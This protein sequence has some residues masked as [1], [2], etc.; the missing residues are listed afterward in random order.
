MWF[1]WLGWCVGKNMLVWSYS[2]NGVALRGQKYFYMK[3]VKSVKVFKQISSSSSSSSS[4]LS[5]GCNFVF[6]R[7]LFS[8]FA[9]FFVQYPFVGSTSVCWYVSQYARLKM[10]N[11]GG[12]IHM[13]HRSMLSHVSWIW[14]V[15]PSWRYIW[16][17]GGCVGSGW[18]CGGSKRKVREG[19][20]EKNK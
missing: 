11:T 10:M 7:S 20:K 8:T 5:Q 14:L 16:D 2:K 4:W 6:K 15:T 19:E 12:D 1:L 9:I 13:A 17:R 18:G 3:M